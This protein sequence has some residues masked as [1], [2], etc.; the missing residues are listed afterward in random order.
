VVYFKASWSTAFDPAQTTAV[1]F[2]RAD[3]TQVDC[4]MMRQSGTFQYLQTASVQVVRLPYGKNN[5]M[6]M[7]IVLPQSGVTLNAMAAGL[8]AVE[9]DSWVTQLGP[10]QVSVGLPRF[11]TSYNTSLVAP[12][13]AL[14]MG[15]A[16]S[17]LDANFSALAPGDFVS[18]VQHATVVRVDESGTV[19]AGSTSVGVSPTL[20]AQAVPMIMDRPF[21][22]AIRDDQTGVLLFVGLMFDPSQG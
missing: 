15:V 16:F 19:A 3:G 2:T 9:L 7:L 12:L 6:S 8:T 20:V 1:P 13:T 10:Q 21:L 17:Q 5:R 14:G 11:T 18:F 22:Y 4:Q